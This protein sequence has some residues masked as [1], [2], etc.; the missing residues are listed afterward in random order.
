MLSAFA[1]SQS[2]DWSYDYSASESNMT[3]GMPQSSI[4]QVTVD[5]NAM[6]IGAAIGVFYQDNDDNYICSGSI[7]WDYQ[8][9]VIPVWGGLSGIQDGQDFTL[10][11]FVNGTTYLVGAQLATTTKMNMMHIFFKWL[12]FQLQFYQLET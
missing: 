12:T 1:Y 11:S 5:G 7:I 9:N 3:I 2:L 8:S 10:F 4:D 6:P